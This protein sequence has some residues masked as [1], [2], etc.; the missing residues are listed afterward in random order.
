MLRDACLA[1]LR[2]FVLKISRGVWKGCVYVARNKSTAL[3]SALPPPP[4]RKYASRSLCRL[5]RL[6]PFEK[7]MQTP[8]LQQKSKY[9][10]ISLMRCIFRVKSSQHTV[11]WLV[12]LVRL[13]NLSQTP[14]FPDE[15]NF[16]GRQLFLSSRY[17]LSTRTTSKHG[18][19][20]WIKWT[21]LD[22]PSLKS[23]SQIWPMILSSFSMVFNPDRQGSSIE[24]GS[25]G[26]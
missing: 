5:V 15:M 12:R 9:F 13:A 20:T 17:N 26:G 7:P 22:N 3:E 10:D 21:V 4:N 14:W 18:F 16:S 24:I 11:W 6:V 23:S 2:A 25:Y 19:T 8:W 1:F